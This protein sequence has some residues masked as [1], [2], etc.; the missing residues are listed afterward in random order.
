MGS[1][2]KYVFFE[3][4]SQ[5]AVRVHSHS[6]TRS[7]HTNNRN[8]E[9]GTLIMVDIPSRHEIN[10][11]SSH[12]YLAAFGMCNGMCSVLRPYV[13]CVEHN[14]N[15]HYPMYLV[16]VK[17]HNVAHISCYHIL[18][19]RCLF[20]ARRGGTMTFEHLWST[21]THTHTPSK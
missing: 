20:L 10:A 2:V 1:W 17:Y 19:M 13:H 4:C 21:H 7:Q 12:T 9:H 18:Q 14:T 5:H 3:I 16:Y 6:F 8:M 11:C 15:T